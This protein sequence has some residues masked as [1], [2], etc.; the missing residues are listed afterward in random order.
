MYVLIL[1]LRIREFRRDVVIRKAAIGDV[2]CC[3]IKSSVCAGEAVHTH[4]HAESRT[5]ETVI[6]RMKTAGAVS[7]SAALRQLESSTG[8]HPI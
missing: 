3:I 1:E 2:R 4:A 6:N 8:E 5:A 7:P